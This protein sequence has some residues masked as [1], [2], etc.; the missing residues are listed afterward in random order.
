MSPLKLFLDAAADLVWLEASKK[1]PAISPAFCADSLPFV[2][3]PCLPSL[4]AKCLGLAIIAGA[5]VVKLPLFRNI[6]RSRS[7]AGI[8][9]GSSYGE[10]LMY[11]N[12]VIYSILCG[13]PFTA[14]GE[15]A[16]NLVQCFVLVHL[17][18]KYPSSVGSAVS[19]RE[20]L[21]FLSATMAYF[22]AC[23]TVLPER[24]YY[25]II[26][27]NWPTMVYSRGTQIILNFRAGNTGQMAF[28]TVFMQWGGCIARIG[29][30]IKEVGWDLSLLFGYSLG[31]V[32]NTIL[33]LQVLLYRERTAQFR[34]EIFGKKE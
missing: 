9:R 21:L 11:S 20:R 29:T 22:V 6:L 5:C 34:K 23:G 17:L 26:A 33:C 14:W 2:P 8:S 19:V 28:F 16:V 10:V 12:A 30:T 18:W 27:M 31:A 4:A 1:D 7:T 3:L 15:T 32:F 24:Y 13:N 25:L